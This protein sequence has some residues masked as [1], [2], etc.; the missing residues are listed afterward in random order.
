[1]LKEL[2][3]MSYV[4]SDSIVFSLFGL[5]YSTDFYVETVWIGS[6]ILSLVGW[7]IFRIYDSVEQE[8]FKRDEAM[9]VYNASRNLAYANNSN[10]REYEIKELRV[11]NLKALAF[12]LSCFIIIVSV[13]W[14]VFSL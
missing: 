14:F 6:L 9:R 11:K 7:I 5:T 13:A 1:M 10:L 2:F 3:I 4:S 12:L 8:R